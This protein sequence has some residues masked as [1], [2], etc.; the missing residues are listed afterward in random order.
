M[1]YNCYIKPW[2]V[3]QLLYKFIRTTGI[4]Q[5]HTDLNHNIALYGI[6]WLKIIGLDK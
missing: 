3:L 4:D 2:Y 1:F 5:V 6:C